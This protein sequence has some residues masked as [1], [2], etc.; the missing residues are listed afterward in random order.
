[1]I[2]ALGAAKPLLFAGTLARDFSLRC[3]IDGVASWGSFETV[4]TLLEHGADSNAMDNRGTTPLMSIAGTK[5]TLRARD[6]IDLLVKSGASLEAR[7]QY[8]KTAADYARSAS[9]PDLQN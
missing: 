7:D 1:M 4:K 2:G 5:G 3:T 6:I 9:N 8:G